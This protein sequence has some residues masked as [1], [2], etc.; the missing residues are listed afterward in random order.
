MRDDILLELTIPILVWNILSFILI[1]FLLIITIK[2]Y[3][4]QA[5]FS[6]LK[7]E[8]LISCLIHQVSMTPFLSFIIDYESNY[9]FFV[10]EQSF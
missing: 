2:N 3:S 5:L 6:Q 8:L 10:M 9:L 1:I 4:E 7:I